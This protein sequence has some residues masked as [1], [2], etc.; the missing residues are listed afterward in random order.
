MDKATTSLRALVGLPEPV[1]IG[2]LTLMIKPL[3]WHES[4]GAIEAIM[5]ALDSMPLLPTNVPTEGSNS[6]GTQDLGA[7]LSWAAVYRDDVVEFCHLASGQD[8]EDIKAISPTEL[9]ELI[10]GILRINADFFIKSLPGLAARVGDQVSGL[11]AKVKA[12]AR[13]PSA[14]SSSASSKTATASAS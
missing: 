10:F 5:P 7:W 6:L 1:Q 8:R 12:A 3:G 2:S 13:P 14:T 9:L 4:V 11:I